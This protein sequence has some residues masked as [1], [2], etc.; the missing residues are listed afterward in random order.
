MSKARAQLEA[1]PLLCGS[2][3]ASLTPLARLR[4]E[5]DILPVNR[6]VDLLVKEGVPVRGRPLSPSARLPPLPGQD[7]HDRGKR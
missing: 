3:G 4:A 2:A 5:A 7:V 1:S 6:E